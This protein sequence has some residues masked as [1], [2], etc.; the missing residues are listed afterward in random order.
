MPIDN[1]EIKKA[2]DDFEKEDFLAAKD[3]IGKEVKGAIS[4]YFKDKLELKNDL[5][6]KPD[7][8]DTKVA[9]EV[10]AED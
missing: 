3:R 2:L 7:V 9:A 6:P 10:G 5:V 1:T 8:V 4:D